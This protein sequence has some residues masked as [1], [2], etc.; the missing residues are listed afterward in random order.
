MN[1]QFLNDFLKMRSNLM[2]KQEEEIK[3]PLSKVD[4]KPTVKV[5][6]IT[7][8]QIIDDKPKQKVVIEYFK[9]LISTF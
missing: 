3:K 2:K 6:Q 5:D 7:L 9:N 1:N 4:V 8:K